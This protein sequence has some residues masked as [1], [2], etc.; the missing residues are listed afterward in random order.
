MVEQELITT[1]KRI[2][3]ESG[4]IEIFY[5]SFDPTIFIEFFDEDTG[6]D[7]TLEL[8]QLGNLSHIKESYVIRNID[9]GNIKTDQEKEEAVKLLLQQGTELEPALIKKA[10]EYAKEITGRAGIPVEVVDGLQG[11][12]VLMT[13]HQQNMR[14]ASEIL[15]G[16]DDDY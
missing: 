9:L 8:I 11:E 7:Y 2:G 4:L 15:K 6:V 14:H 3:V 5:S 1:I 16:I 10:K 13:V 12:P